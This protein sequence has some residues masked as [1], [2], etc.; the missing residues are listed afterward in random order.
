MDTQVDIIVIGAGPGGYPAAIRAAQ[1]GATV[2]IV[3]REQL[4]GTCL[5]RGCIPTKALIAGAELALQAR[6]A[7][8]VGVRVQGV[9]ADFGAMTEHKD[10]TIQK[11]RGGIA[12]LLKANGV[13]SIEGQA[14]FVSPRRIEIA[15]EEGLRFLS[16]DKVIIATGSESVMPGFLPKHP[17]IV[18]SRAFLELRELPPRL[19]V[20]GGGYIGCELACMA[21]ALGRDVTIVELLD[22]ILLLLDP[23]VRREV[24]KSMEKDLKVRILTGAGL[25]GVEADDTSVRGKVGGE[26]VE[27]DLLL[28]SVGRRPVT[29]GLGLNRIGLALDESGAIPVDDRNRTNV[30]GVYAIG[31]VNGIIQLA[32]AATSQG[33]IAAEDACGR[34]AP[35]NETLVPGV[36]F[37]HPEVATVGLGETAAK[38][39][40][41]AVTV[42]RF[43]YQG[44]GRAVA[45]GKTEGFV[46]W[47]VDAETDQLLGAQAVGAQATDLMAEATVAIRAELTASE[48]G[49]TVHAHPTFGEIWMEAAHAVHGACIHAPPA[50]R[51]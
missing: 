16:A 43:V 42:G 31:D 17:K 2:A 33:I 51:K 26:T 39:E 29:D 38:E 41:R 49:R 6:A 37:T 45:S 18:E 50:R 5:N 47:I 13:T 46:K 32:H 1:L 24:C 15:T 22:D 4:G 28:V 14:S 30:P 23:D 10:R 34:R 9:E 7:E 19:L 40:G 3:E 21:A 20:M 25:E 36:I 48:L 27:A 12:A 35:K 11:L 8:T 44:L